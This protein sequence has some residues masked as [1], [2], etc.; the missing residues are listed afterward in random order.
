MAPC[1]VNTLDMKDNDLLLY[2][3]FN[4]EGD[5][6]KDLSQHGNDGNGGEQV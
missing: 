5:V 6:V 1:I 2:F 3:A 4:E